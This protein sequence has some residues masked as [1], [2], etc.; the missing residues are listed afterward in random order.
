LQ[1]G[2]HNIRWIVN[3]AILEQVWVESIDGVNRYYADTRPGVIM[4]E[5]SWNNVVQE[6]TSSV[7]AVALW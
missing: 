7:Q 3:D 5:L 4:P 6:I 2:I 1:I